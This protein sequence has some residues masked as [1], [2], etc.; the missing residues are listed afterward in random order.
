MSINNVHENKADEYKNITK[1][2][3]ML[4]ESHVEMNEPCAKRITCGN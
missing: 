2:N 3:H 4:Q 1:M